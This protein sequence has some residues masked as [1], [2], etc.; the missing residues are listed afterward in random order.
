MDK[1][2]DSYPRRGNGGGGDEGRAV[3]A[4][5]QTKVNDPAH[6]VRHPQTNH[7]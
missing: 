4:N 6:I 7:T 5:V 1:G 3:V 2:A